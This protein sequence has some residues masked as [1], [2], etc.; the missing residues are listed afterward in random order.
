MHFANQIGVGVFALFVFA[1]DHNKF[2][3]TDRFITIYISS[4]DHFVNL[5]LRKIGTQTSHDVSELVGINRAATICVK[6]LE[7]RLQIIKRLIL[8]ELADHDRLESFKLDKAV[9]H[10]LG[11]VV[12]LVRF[13]LF[14]FFFLDLF[15]ELRDLNWSWHEA[16]ASHALVELS[17]VQHFHFDFLHAA[18]LLLD[19]VLLQGLVL[20]E[21]LLDILLL[22]PGQTAVVRVLQPGLLPSCQFFHLLFGGVLQ[23]GHGGAVGLEDAVLLG[24]VVLVDLEEV[25]AFDQSGDALVHVALSEEDLGLL[26][27][28]LL[29]DRGVRLLEVVTERIKERARLRKLFGN[30]L[31]LLSRFI[32]DESMSVGLENA[33][34]DLI[35]LHEDVL[36]VVLHVGL[37]EDSGSPGGGDLALSL[38]VGDVHAHL[39]LFEF[40]I[41]SGH[42]QG[43]HLGVMPGTNRHLES[44]RIR[45]N[46]LLPSLFVDDDVFHQFEEIALETRGIRLLEGLALRILAIADVWEPLFGDVAHFSVLD[47]SVV[48]LSQFLTERLTLLSFSLLGA[49]RHV[50][51]VVHGGLNHIS[52]NLLLLLNHG[53]EFLVVLL[54][55]VPVAPMERFHDLFFFGEVGDFP[56]D[57]NLLVVGLEVLLQGLLQ[58]LVSDVVLLGVSESLIGFEFLFYHS[59]KDSIMWEQLLEFFKLSADLPLILWNGLLCISLLFD[60]QFLLL[61][62]PFVAKNS[63]FDSI[64]FLNL[65][66]FEKCLL[67]IIKVDFLEFFSVRVFFE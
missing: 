25:E 27:F 52:F 28:A 9:M 54:F 19:L 37:P 4:I 29:E 53:P 60:R 32:L 22:L 33:V 34:L 58:G 44:R 39:E 55:E 41:H 64:L 2:I 40:S 11:Y 49:I 17:D 57:A 12:Q 36:E 14:I 20:V 38:E 30:E 63:L 3:F 67:S 65:L 46:L 48:V 45:G 43:I 10:I 59:L 61:I 18:I 31:L 21:G 1:H 15:D 24:L 13:L 42:D 6:N 62:V 35:L 8:H 51:V 7:G 50:G 26:E 66:L 23:R 47:E 16:E 5:F 56:G